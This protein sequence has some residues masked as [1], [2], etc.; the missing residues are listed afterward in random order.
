MRWLGRRARARRILYPLFPALA[1]YYAISR[2]L[3]IAPIDSALAAAFSSH[4]TEPFRA[5]GR[6][7]T[8]PLFS[9][10]SRPHP[11]G[12]AF[13]RV[14]LSL[15]WCVVQLCGI[16]P[17]LSAVGLRRHDESRGSVILY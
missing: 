4:L 3:A 1:L 17:A 9:F 8:R 15:P 12:S 5:Q 7:L 16:S 10:P 2:L 6:A 13:S 11:S 14:M